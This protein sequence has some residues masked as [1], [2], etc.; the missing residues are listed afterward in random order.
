MGM[1]SGFL[2]TWPI[3]LILSAEIMDDDEEESQALAKSPEA[4]SATL[5]DVAQEH[6][7]HPQSVSAS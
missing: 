2:D 1:V 7:Q 4:E 3:L 5:D 6:S